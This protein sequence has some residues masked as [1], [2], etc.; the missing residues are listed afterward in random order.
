M[1]F[2]QI[3]YRRGV[4]G[5]LALK[6]L[7]EKTYPRTSGN[8]GLGDLVSALQW[9]QLNIQHFGGHPA[10]VTLLGRGTGATLVTAMSAVPKAKN[11]FHKIWA[12]NGAGQFGAKNPDKADQQN[13]AS[14]Y[15]ISKRIKKLE[16]II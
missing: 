12:T 8:Y 14:I 16:F 11:L 15:I 9:I 6:S 3:N 7:A 1:V 10:K 2:V 4:L 5:F 13:K